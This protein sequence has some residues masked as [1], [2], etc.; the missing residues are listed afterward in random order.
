MIPRSAALASVLSYS[1]CQV[2]MII[3]NKALIS[4]YG[5]KEVTFLLFS[6]N[7]GLAVALVLIWVVGGYRWK[8][9]RNV[10]FALIPLWGLYICY[11]STGLRSL[12][13]LSV[14]IYTLMK[15]S[16]LVFIA[17][18]E[19]VIHSTQHTKP[20]LASL[21]IILT[22]IIIGQDS[23]GGTS[24]SRIG[25]LWMLLHM[26]FNVFYAIYTREVM[27]R[28]KPSKLESLTCSCV[29]SLPLYGMMI[30]GFTAWEDSVNQSTFLSFFF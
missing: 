20:V 1:A 29:V 27:D 13:V 6:Q 8:V 24:S 30:S 26:Y 21:F 3:V 7:V 10:F 17:V 5:F 16:C 2:V 23:T 25:I 15:N 22:G 11:L 4:F 28:W 9:S 14:P 18:V 12:D 19:N